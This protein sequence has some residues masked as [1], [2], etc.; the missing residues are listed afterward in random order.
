MR[1]SVKLGLS[2]AFQ[3]QRTLGNRVQK[4]RYTLVWGTGWKGVLGMVLG[5]D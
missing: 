5:G 4:A 1:R 2:K 3:S